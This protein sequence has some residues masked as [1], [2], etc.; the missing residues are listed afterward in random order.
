MEIRDIIRNIITE[1]FTISE[2]QKT[3]EFD[4]K[5]DEVISMIQL[6]DL[7]PDNIKQNE[8]VI[9]SE[10]KN[11]IKNKLN[12][13]YNNKSFGYKDFNIVKLG[14]FIIKTIGGTHEL[15]FKMP[16]TEK[17]FS[18]IYVYVYNDKVMEF[19]FGSQFHDTD[20]SLLENAEKYIRDNRIVIDRMSDAGEVKVVNHLNTNNVIDL[21]DYSKIKKK[22]S[23]P[24]GPK[25]AKSE[26][27]TGAPVNHPKFG[28]GIIEKTKKYATLEDGAT[29]YKITV[30][31]SDKT[32]DLLVVPSREKEA[33]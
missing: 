26:Y 8:M 18:Y 22:E 2:V 4:Q 28:K 33:V 19:K 30:R 29:Q 12:H 14:T 24:S 25:L 6:G 16:D 21:I 20:K 23:E 9:M 11:A 32:R 3:K 13:V 15:S 1:Q 17:G 27:R 5:L 31:F 10:V 7:E